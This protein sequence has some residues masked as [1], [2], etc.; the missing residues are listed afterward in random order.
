MTTHPEY[1]P[2]VVGDR[3]V[4]VDA[5][6][7]YVNGWACYTTLTQGTVYTVSRVGLSEDE[8]L[9]VALAEAPKPFEPGKDWGWMASRFRP[10]PSISVFTELLNKAPVD[11]VVG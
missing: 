10:A 5:G 2:F 9:T 8:I 1:C 4:C 7:R 3:V 6:P 11:E